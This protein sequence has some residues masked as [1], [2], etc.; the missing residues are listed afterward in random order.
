METAPEYAVTKKGQQKANKETTHTTPSG[1]LVKSSDFL[2]IRRMEIQRWLSVIIPK[3]EA[4]RGITI[5]DKGEE[6]KNVFLLMLENEL[7]NDFSFDSNRQKLAEISLLKLDWTYKKAYFLELSDFYPSEQQIKSFM[8]SSSM[9]LMTRDELALKV[10]KATENAIRDYEASQ[11]PPQPLSEQEKVLHEA[12]IEFYK[13][14]AKTKDELTHLQAQLNVL[15]YRNKFLET[16]NSELRKEIADYRLSEEEKLRK[17]SLEAEETIRR[18]RDKKVT[19]P[20]QKLNQVKNPTAIKD[21]LKTLEI[22]H[23]ESNNE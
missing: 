13:E 10:R 4:F 11:P 23:G 14:R 5:V 15:E 9:V 19:I 21:L 18:L 3:V 7:V 8:A 12:W 20:I 6:A 22:Q 16:R 2:Q 17:H 1:G